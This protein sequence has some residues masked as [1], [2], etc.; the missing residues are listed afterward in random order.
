VKH[1][2][3]LI[4]IAVLSVFL[5]T[6]VT[7][8]PQPDRLLPQEQRGKEIYFGDEASSGPPMKALY[9]NPPA[10]LPA[11]MMGCANCHGES[12]E[13]NPEAKV[14]SRIITWAALTKPYSPVGPTGRAR[15]AYTEQLLVRAVCMGIDPAGNYLHVTMPRFQMSREDSKALIAYPKRLGEKSEKTP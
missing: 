8:K 4:A 2:S 1:F 7:L 15:P 11:S 14:A 6:P 9:G 10:E 3:L 12:G 5:Q 13:G